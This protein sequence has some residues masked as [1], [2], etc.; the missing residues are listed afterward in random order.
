MAALLVSQDFSKP[1]QPQRLLSGREQPHLT[2]HALGHWY[3]VQTAAALPM[4]FSQQ[5]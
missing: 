2:E 3:A 5:G 4:K 1:S